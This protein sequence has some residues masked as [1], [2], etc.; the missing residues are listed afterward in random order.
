M[1]TC[2]DC[3]KPTRGE[4]CRPHAAKSRWENPTPAQLRQL[5]AARKARYTRK[6]TEAIDSTRILKLIRAGGHS[7][8]RIEKTFGWGSG[9]LRHSLERGRLNARRLDELASLLGR[10][11]EELIA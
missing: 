11:F 2:I 8:N 10:H 3:G 1:A 6:P 4:R 9:Y 5:K 7:F